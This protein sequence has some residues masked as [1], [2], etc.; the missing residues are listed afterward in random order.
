M[1]VAREIKWRISLTRVLL[2]LLLMVGCLFYFCT[3]TE[4][5]ELILEKPGFWDQG[6]WGQQK[7]AP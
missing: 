1:K 5:G 4:I 6:S 2:I 3:N 7:W